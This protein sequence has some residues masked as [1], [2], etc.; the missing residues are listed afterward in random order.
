MPRYNWQTPNDKMVEYA[1]N[2]RAASERFLAEGDIVRALMFEQG[3]LGWE[4]AIA[5]RKAKV[6]DALIKMSDL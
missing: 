4:Y 5:K 6:Y 1:A 2:C 3:A